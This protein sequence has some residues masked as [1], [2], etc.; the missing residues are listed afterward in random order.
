[1]DPQ[2]PF[3]QFLTDSTSNVG[4]VRAGSTSFADDILATLYSAKVSTQH[5]P[6]PHAKGLRNPSHCQISS[7]SL[8][9]VFSLIHS[10]D[11]SITRHTFGFVVY[12]YQALHPAFS[13][14][15]FQTHQESQRHLNLCGRQCATFCSGHRSG[16]RGIF[17]QLTA[18]GATEA[19][20]TSPPFEGVG[21]NNLFRSLLPSKAGASLSHRATKLA[22]SLFPPLN[23]IYVN[24]D[25]M[26]SSVYFTRRKRH[27]TRQV[28]MLVLMRY[29][30]AFHNGFV[31]KP[32]IYVNVHAEA[33]LR[34]KT[35]AVFA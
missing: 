31:H 7:L 26:S 34:D 21:A 20:I 13:G 2:L 9:G 11:I 32:E 28:T 24:F 33:S 6:F 30:K 22:V 14:F 10:Y 29:H 23:S 35:V 16:V 15:S 8:Q 12:N 27:R 18:W 17:A 1:M 19:T 3:S 4:Q 25:I 5:M